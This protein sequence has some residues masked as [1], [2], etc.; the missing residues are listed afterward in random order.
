M[1]TELTAQ[2]EIAELLSQVTEQEIKEEDVSHRLLFVSS[3]VILLV[4]VMYADKQV[5][6]SEKQR[7]KALIGQFIRN[8]SKSA[9]SPRAIAW[10][11]GRAVYRSQT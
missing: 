8:F 4:G 10:A 7:V 2:Q 6:E 3:L 1:L 9:V 11:L 5:T